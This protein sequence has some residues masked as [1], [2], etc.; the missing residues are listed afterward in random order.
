MALMRP[1]A[2][3]RRLWRSPRPAGTNVEVGARQP[4][5]SIPGRRVKSMGNVKFFSE[6]ICD[7]WRFWHAACYQL[8]VQDFG[9]PIFSPGNNPPG[10]AIG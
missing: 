3:G 7:G 1:F 5:P 9:R 4:G 2:A 10:G 6:K 8:M